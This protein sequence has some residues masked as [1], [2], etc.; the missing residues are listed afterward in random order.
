MKNVGKELI[1]FSPSSSLVTQAVLALSAMNARKIVVNEREAMPTRRPTSLKRRLIILSDGEDSSPPSIPILPPPKPT[2]SK[3]TPPRRTCAFIDDE[4]EEDFEAERNELL[5]LNKS[6]ANDEEEVADATPPKEGGLIKDVNTFASDLSPEAFKRLQALF[7]ACLTSTRV[8]KDGALTK[9]EALEDELDKLNDVVRD[10]KTKLEAALSLNEDATAENS[11]LHEEV[12]RLITKVA[13]ET[14]MTRY[15][16][17]LGHGGGGGNGG[18]GGNGSNGGNV[19]HNSAA[20]NGNP[21]RA[22]INGGGGGGGGGGDD[23]DDGDDGGRGGNPPRDCGDPPL[24]VGEDVH[25]EEHENNVLPPP[26]VGAKV[27]APKPPSPP[28]T[29]AY[30]KVK[31]SPWLK[32]MLRYF[33]LTEYA[34]SKRVMYAISRMEPEDSE[35]LVKVLE[36]ASLTDKTAS[37]DQYVHA[38]SEAF[39]DKGESQYAAQNLQNVKQKAT[40]NV[41]QYM[42]RWDTEHRLIKASHMPAVWQLCQWFCAGLANHELAQSCVVARNGAPWESITQL[43]L[44]AVELTC[45]NQALNWATRP[46]TFG[47]GPMRSHARPPSRNNGGGPSKGPKFFGRNHGGGNGPKGPKPFGGGSGPPNN[48]HGRQLGSPPTVTCFKC[49][50]IGHKANVRRVPNEKRKFETMTQM[51]RSVLTMAMAMAMVLERNR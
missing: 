11:Y 8:A 32:S 43:T 10:L 41:M 28:K 46:S 45:A 37:W 27:L 36:D 48:F 42:R 49:G 18:D 35:R 19:S 51:A 7:A 38:M 44:Y 15:M 14:V 30:G 5:G 47:H 13:R 20:N 29:F 34:S 2:P 16:A 4:A 23:G 3:P 9:I 25:E 39:M 22:P 24:D 31:V 1:A 6:Y 12:R 40:E 17:A 26:T 21:P 33:D 50:K